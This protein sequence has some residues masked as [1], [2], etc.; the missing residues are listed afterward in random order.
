MF[1][2][3]RTV[4]FNFQIY[5]IDRFY[6]Q[7]TVVGYATI[8]LFV[9]VGTERQPT[10]DKQGLQVLKK[11]YFQVVLICFIANRNHFL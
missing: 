7:I 6:K 3:T 5:T 9:E 10:I 2:I 1:I 11:S 4:F 8:N